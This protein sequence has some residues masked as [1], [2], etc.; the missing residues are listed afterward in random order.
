[1][2]PFMTPTKSNEFSWKL[3][4]KTIMNEIDV[5]IG[6]NINVGETLTKLNGIVL[7]MNSITHI[8]YIKKVLEFL[9]TVFDELWQDWLMFITFDQNIGKDVMAPTS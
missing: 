9:S 1:M 6:N 3:S 4:S 5:K 2:E 8:Q 7:F